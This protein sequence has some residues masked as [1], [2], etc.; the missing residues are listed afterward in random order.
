MKGRLL[1]RF[2]ALIKRYTGTNSVVAVS[3]F[4]VELL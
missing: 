3:V 1:G 2:P 4:D